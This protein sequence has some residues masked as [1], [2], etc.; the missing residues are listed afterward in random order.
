M[1]VCMV[2]A[3]DVTVQ[4]T[5]LNLLKDIQDKFNVACL[6]ISHDPGVIRQMCDEV[7]EMG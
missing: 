6:F 1:V 7:I 2:S 3:L 5:I 4:A